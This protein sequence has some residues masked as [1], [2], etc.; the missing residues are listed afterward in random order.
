MKISML[1]SLVITAFTA[2][3]A[4]A[5]VTENLNSGAP[6]RADDSPRSM[7]QAVMMSEKSAA[8]ERF[9]GRAA[10]SHRIALEAM[11]AEQLAL[12]LK[13]AAAQRNA[14]QRQPNIVGLGRDVPSGSQHVDFASLNWETVAGGLRVARVELGIPS[15]AGM[16][17]GYRVTGPVEKL[18]VRSGSLGAS[19]AFIGAPLV[20]GERAWSPTIESE[21]GVL[22][23]AIAAG[24]RP[25]DFSLTIEKISQLA[26]VGRD[27]I[28]EKRRAPATC[29]ASPDEIGCSDSC[30]VDFSCVAN[31]SQALI[32]ASRATAKYYYVDDTSGQ[33]RICTGTLL[34]SNTSP[35]RPYFFTAAHCINSQRDAASIESYWFF[36]SVACNALNTPPYQR[37]TTGMSARVVDENMDVSLLEMN[38]SPPSG[39]VFAAWEASVI[40]RNAVL[41]GI[42]HPQGDLKAF[43]EGTMQGYEKV[44]ALDTF[45]KVRWTPGKGTTEAGSSGSGI[46][47]FRSDCGSGVSCYELRGGLLGGGASCATPTSPDYYSRMDLLFTKL[48]PYLSPAAQ[49]PVTTSTQAAM[50]EFY[51]PELDYYFMTSRENEKSLLDSLTSSNGDYRWYRT[52]YWFKAD[53]FSSP[54]TNSLTRYFIPGAAKNQT[55]GTHFYTALNSDKQVITNT[56]RERAGSA[57]NGMPNGFFCNEGTDSYVAPPIGTGATAGCASG[58]RAIWRVFRGNTRFPD[59]P[60]HRY[61]TSIGMYNYMISDQGWDAEFVNM[62]ARP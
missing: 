27:A 47:T 36:D 55:R 28:A 62:C 39:A 3:A 24:A 6:T 12:K 42:H 41:V 50:V 44:S 53:P 14:M 10:A 18:V 35:R 56:G 40:P 59:D 7:G 1:S 60:N 61:V 9:L 43:S 30:N 32:D 17:V 31:P 29:A 52:G 25:R 45:I 21:S 15:A 8:P 34:N 13:S 37:L 22:E 20:S 57:C 16:R 23:F 26:K 5:V 49:I 38:S 4:M 2:S 11:S 51:N 48:T 58:E 19:E 46:F 33:T 54:S